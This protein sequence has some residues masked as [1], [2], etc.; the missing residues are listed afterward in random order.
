M[1]LDGLP[2]VIDS[3]TATVS[4]VGKAAGDFISQ[5]PAAALGKVG[6]AITGA[7]SGLAGLFKPLSGVKLPLANPLFK[8]ATYDYVLGIYALDDTSLNNPD[9]GYMKSLMGLSCICKSANSDPKNRVTTAFGKFDFFIEKLEINSQ[10]G[11]EKGDNSNMLNGSITIVEPY[12]MGLFMMSIQEAA[13]KAGHANYLVAPFLLTIDFRGNTESGSMVNIPNTSRRIPFTFLNISMKVTEKGAVYTADLQHASAGALA[14]DVNELKTDVS[15]SGAT[16]Q[17]A[18]QTGE[19]SLQVALNTRLQQL[20]KDKIVEEPDQILILFPT[21]TSSEG[22][23]SGEQTED[24]TGATTTSDAES[25][26]SVSAKLGVTV[27]SKNKTLIQSAASCNEIGKSKM[28][29]DE[30]RKG[31]APSGKDNKV[32]NSDLKINVRGNNTVD[33]K[34][35]DLKFRQNSDVINAIN[36]TILASEYAKTAM[37][38]SGI[39]DKGFRKWWRIDTQVYNI[40]SNANMSTTG[41]KPRLIVYRVVPYM[42][43]SGNVAAP[44]S[45][46]PGYD[47]V[48]VEVVKEYNYIYTGKNVDI[49][50]FDITCQLGFAGSMSAGPETQTQDNKTKAQQGGAEEKGVTVQPV[51][52]GSDPSKKPGTLPTQNRYSNTN[53]PTDKKG[54]GGVETQEQR[55]AKQFHEAMSSGADMIQLEMQIIGDPYYIA[56]SGTGNYTA[57]PSQYMNLNSDNTINYQSGEVDILVNFRTPVDINQTTGMYDFGKSSKSAPVLSWSG[58]YHLL[59]VT[60][61]FDNGQFKQTLK[62]NRRPLQDLQGSGNITSVS[63]SDNTKVNPND[64]NGYGEG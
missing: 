45:K 64:P 6:D 29:F 28:G 41:T 24:N 32:Y 60:S 34:V 26:S 57:K 40:T 3:A 48:K 30:V 47:S 55:A 62:G 10:L 43:H 25:V 38:K 22:A 7:L 12:S 31:D 53:R 39:D 61:S 21:D 27:S 14:S 18:L 51:D 1:S 2:G 56:Q 23:A 13:W 44:N 16:V 54:G 8:Y 4:S 15:I 50:N 11:M 5:G 36:Q 59:T 9:T 63:N 46:P 58:L 35:S 37:K 42:A 19:K 49:L 17:E 20:K 33:P 52:K